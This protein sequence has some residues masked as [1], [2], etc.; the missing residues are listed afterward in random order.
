MGRLLRPPLYRHLHLATV[1]TGLPQVRSTSGASP[2]HRQP[3]KGPW[4]IRTW[5]GIR[6]ESKLKTA[7]REANIKRLIKIGL[8][9]QYFGVPI[10]GFCEVRGRIDNGA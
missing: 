7:N 5:S 1:P 10:F 2:L 8:V 9:P 6:N 4:A 3:P